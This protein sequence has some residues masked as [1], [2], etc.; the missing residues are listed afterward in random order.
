[1]MSYLDDRISFNDHRHVQC[2]FFFLFFVL[3]S[4]KRQNASYEVNAEINERVSIWRGDITTLEIDAITNAANSSLLGGG[5]G[6]YM[7]W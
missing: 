6:K 5:G 1:M 4:K 3:V 2:G 7:Y